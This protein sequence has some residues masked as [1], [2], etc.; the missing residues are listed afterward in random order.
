MEG[1]V[2]EGGDVCIHRANSLR[3]TA[4]TNTAL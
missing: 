3:C 4:K 2:Q 1:D